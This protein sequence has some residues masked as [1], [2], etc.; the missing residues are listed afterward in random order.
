MG[1]N[2]HSFLSLTDCAKFLKVDTSTV[3]KR[4]IKK[5][6]FMF[7]NKIAYIKDE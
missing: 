4:K 1:N 5:I 6:P 3:S 2:L 7:E